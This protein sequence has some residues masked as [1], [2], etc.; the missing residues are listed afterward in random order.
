MYIPKWLLTRWTVSGFIFLVNSL[1]KKRPN[2]PHVEEREFDTIGTRVLFEDK[3]GS[4]LAKLL[5]W[6]LLGFLPENTRGRK[7]D[8]D[9]VNMPTA[10]LWLTYPFVKTRH[11]KF[12]PR[13]LAPKH[14]IVWTTY[15]ISWCFRL[16]IKRFSCIVLF[17]V[18]ARGWLFPP[19]E[20]YIFWAVVG[21]WPWN[22]LYIGT[23][24]TELGE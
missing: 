15:L 20:E 19:Y 12:M 14:N 5:L 21:I 16:E 18:F 13:C 7:L 11:G 4:E 3:N 1:F 17:W 22:S 8:T 2:L 10:F 24:G 23:K 6:F 9:E